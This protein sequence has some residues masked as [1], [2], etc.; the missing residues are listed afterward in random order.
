MKIWLEKV[1]AYFTS[2]TMWM[3]LTLFLFLSHLLMLFPTDNG[4]VS[5]TSNFLVICLL[6]FPVLIFSGFRN[7]W[8]HSVNRWLGT[9]VW[10]YSF[11]G[12]PLL[13]FNWR[14]ELPKDYFF[15]S[16]ID[17]T[18]VGVDNFLLTIGGV[19]LLTEVAILFNDRLRHGLFK[20]KWF[21][22]IGL[23]SMIL[24]L[25]GL[26]SLIGSI[27]GVVGQLSQG[28]NWSFVSVL[29]LL[30]NFIANLIQIFVIYLVYYF[31][32][33]IN[34]YLLIP[35]I[36]KEKGFIY[37]G[38]SIAAVILV[39]YP[40]LVSLVSLLPVVD[41]LG[42]SRFTGTSNIFAEDAGGLPFV[43]MV[44]TVPVI[45]GYEWFKQ[46]S[47]LA[48]L[49]KEK[50][51]T[52]L[53]LLK[54]QI[55]PHF[56]FNTLN[57]LYALSITKDEQTP[58]V[59]LQLSELMRY[60]IYKGKEETVSLEEEVKYI[61]DYIQLQQIR[62]HKKLDFKF[63]KEILD[64]ALR[65]PPLLFIVLVENAFKHGIEPAE[66][67]CFLHLKLTTTNNSLRFRCTNSI[68]LETANE[69]GIGLT[70]LKRRLALLYPGQHRLTV[71]SSD[72]KY[73]INIAL[74]WADK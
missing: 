57:N 1:T 34:H 58:E 7:W 12:H 68:E 50:S 11:I 24:L 69:S 4:W 19:L 59:I 38:F 62:L 44:L 56:F 43:I 21:E 40:V 2:T 26:L 23:E 16:K 6:F 67:A 36:F 41:Q 46:N 35:R 51:A 52:E 20:T 27:I 72:N 64:S 48:V 45:I 61:E 15:F 10:I 29:L 53:N 63:D 18:V 39:F 54:Q 13:L 28:F 32:Y 66:E 22:S 3:Y 60:V 5:Y 70:N 74:Q 71:D 49:E 33:Y 31:F 47:E 25:L 14:N 55:N 9:M 30:L 8:M 65:I 42:F 17:L 37:Y 73:D